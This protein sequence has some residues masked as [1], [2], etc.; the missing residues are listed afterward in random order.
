MG[1]NILYTYVGNAKKYSLANDLEIRCFKPSIRNLMLS[2][3]NKTGYA[4][5]YHNT[6]VELRWAA[7]T[8]FGYRI[9]YV[10]DGNRIIHTSYCAHK[11]FKFPFMKER[12]WHIG[13]CHTDDDYQGR[14]IY[15]AVLQ[16]ICVNLQ[17]KGGNF[18]MIVEDSNVPSTKGVLKAGFAN[19]GALNKSKYLKKYR[20]R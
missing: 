12:D 3:S 20:L 19:V 17:D 9:F 2:L 11:C 16:Y 7:V 14:N 13:P 15:P 6:W 4:D 5:D 8:H 10:V 18:Y 1:T